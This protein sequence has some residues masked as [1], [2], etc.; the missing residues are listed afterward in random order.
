MTGLMTT[1]IH[2][3]AKGF[4]PNNP[5]LPVVLYEGAFS[6]DE[7]DLAT[8]MEKRFQENGWPPQ[9]RDGIF[10]YDHY[11]TQGHEVLG[12]AAGSAALV[13]G[14]EDGRRITVKAGD[15]L[16]LPAGTGHRRVQQS[17][18]FLVV[19]AYPPGQSPDIICKEA[20]PAMLNQIAILN[21]PQSDPVSGTEGPM[22]QLWA[23]QVVR[24]S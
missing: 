7:E 5:R 22:V 11:H 17:E 13:L 6:A 21:F 15:V 18:D 2:L 9:W 23:D 10:D 14:G 4:I 16:L 19:G 24:K 3:E 8:V 20:T 1:A 12:V